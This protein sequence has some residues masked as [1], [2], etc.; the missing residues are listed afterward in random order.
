MSNQVHP[1]HD[2][3]DLAEPDEWRQGRQFLA[4]AAV[5]KHAQFY[6]GMPSAARARICSCAGSNSGRWLSTLHTEEALILN[7]PLFRN[8]LFCR[9]G[10][11]VL[12]YADTCGGCRMEMD[13]SEWELIDFSMKTK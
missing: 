4:S 3:D 13:M 7:C 12:P 11:P 6:V 1:R 5:E 2:D 9:L 10:L 8:A